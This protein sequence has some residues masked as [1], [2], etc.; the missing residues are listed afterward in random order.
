MP[1]FPAPRATPPV[2]GARENHRFPANSRVP[3]FPGWCPFPAVKVFLLPPR[4]PRKSLREFIASFFCVHI[5]PTE[6]GRLSARNQGCPPPYAQPVN[7]LP[8]VTRRIP[9]YGSLYVI[10]VSFPGDIRRLNDAS[11]VTE[12]LAGT[13]VGR[14]AAVV[15]GGGKMSWFW[16]NIPLMLLFCVLL[17][18][19]PAVAYAH[20]LGRRAEG[21]ARRDRGTSHRRAA[22]RIA[23]TG[24]GRPARGRPPSLRRGWRAGLV[25]PP[26]G[27]ACLLKPAAGRASR[28]LQPRLMAC[29]RGED[30]P[31][32]GRWAADGVNEASVFTHGRPAGKREFTGNGGVARRV[33]PAGA[34]LHRQNATRPPSCMR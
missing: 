27:K 1:G 12:G 3:G 6:C 25:V 2:P 23:G 30:L 16:L 29:V 5:L 4:G 8:G 21:K 9:A 34:P 28:P 7:R 32:G 31:G 19:D 33:A 15:T 17:G 18:R 24:S 22:R 10:A 20:P 13:L 26:A 11:I 14:V